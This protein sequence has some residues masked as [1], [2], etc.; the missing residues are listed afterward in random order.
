MGV[1][2]LLN[3]RADPLHECCQGM[4]FICPDLLNQ[5]LQHVAQVMVVRKRSRRR[6]WRGGETIDFFGY[7]RSHRRFF[8]AAE[9]LRSLAL[10]LFDG[11]DRLRAGSVTTVQLN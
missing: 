8:I 4:R 10:A 9:A 3:Q 2:V 11:G 1:L 6:Q 7:T 5:L